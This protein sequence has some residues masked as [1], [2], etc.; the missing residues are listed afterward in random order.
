[1]S[2]PDSLVAPP[3]TTSQHEWLRVRTYLQEHR[4][5]LSAAAAEL[6]PAAIKVGGTPLLSDP[7]W[8]PAASVPLTSVSLEWHPSHVE[9]A[10]DGTE[11]FAELVRPERPDGRRYESYSAAMAELAAPRVFQNRST[12]RLVHATLA[13]GRPRM[14]FQPG[15][16]FD[17]IDVG[18][19][20]AHEFAAARMGLID[21]TPLRDAVGNPC[22]PA[23]RGTNIAISTLTLRHDKVTG[24]ATFPLHWRD[25][26][27][28]GHASA[29]YTVLP[30]GVFQASGDLPGHLHNDF[31]LW[32][33]MVREFAEELLGEPEDHG[34]DRI[35]YDAW[36]FAARMTEALSAGHIRAQ[37]LALGVDP[38]T[39]AT[40][41]LTVVTVP[42]DLYDD[43]FS[44]MVDTNEEGQLARSD[45][46]QDGRWAMTD[47]CMQQLAARPMQ[48]AG[49]ALVRL[50]WRGLQEH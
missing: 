41:L 40:D 45:C 20:C 24:E 4:Q 9:P 21:G 46:A 37:T 30:V 32:R 39:L 10:V 50:V 34:Y 13:G 29:L 19:A 2:R 6:Y 15:T 43:L 16:Y 12:Y 1:M 23:C 14:A 35:D 42:A 27:K 3:L 26:A 7:S 31:S 22:D 5:E 25:P 36:P 49:A 8:F 38:L 44:R 33:S 28:V 11:P 47:E 18:E 17:G 48:A